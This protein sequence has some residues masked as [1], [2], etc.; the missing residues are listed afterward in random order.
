[1]NRAK[2]NI[3]TKIKTKSRQFSD[4][5]QEPHIKVIKRI[6]FNPVL[7]LCICQKRTKFNDLCKSVP[8]SQYAGLNVAKK[9]TTD[10]KQREV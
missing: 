3:R 9:S 10:L 5:I 4:Q 8:G 1:M 6:Y 2:K 7:Y